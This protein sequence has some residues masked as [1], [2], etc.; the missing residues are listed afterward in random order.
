M[1]EV[2]SLE[3]IPPECAEYTGGRIRFSANGL[4]L[5][6]PNALEDKTIRWC[7]EDRGLS[8]RDSY[9]YANALSIYPDTALVPCITEVFKTKWFDP[10]TGQWKRTGGQITC[11]GFQ[12]CFVEYLTAGREYPGGRRME[13][14][15]GIF[16]PSPKEE[17]C[18]KQDYYRNKDIR[19]AYIRC[20]AG[21]II[22]G[23]S[24]AL[25]FISNALDTKPMGSL[26]E[27][28]KTS[29]RLATLYPTTPAVS[30]P[31][32]PPPTP[33]PEKETG[34]WVWIGLGVLGLL[35]LSEGEGKKKAS[36][37]Q[38]GQL[39]PVQKELFKVPRGR[40]VLK[41]QDISTSEDP[42]M[43][44]LER[45]GWKVKRVQEV[46]EDIAAKKTPD[47]FTG[48]TEPLTGGEKML[49]E[50]IDRCLERMKA[51]R[52][53]RG[54]QPLSGNIMTCESWYEDPYTGWHCFIYAPSCRGQKAC[55]TTGDTRDLKTCV[56]TKLVEP[57]SD[58]YKVKWITRCARYAPACST[59]QCLEKAAPMLR[60]AEPPEKEIKSIAR[61]LAAEATRVQK[62]A[63]PALAREI[64]SRGGIRPY[65]ELK[66]YHLP[67]RRYLMEEYMQIPLFM[68][69]K[70][71]LPLDEMADEM[72]LDEKELLRRISQEYG[73]G[74]VKRR[75]SWKDFYQEAKDIL[76]REYRTT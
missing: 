6:A 14:A 32:S 49:Q 62:E 70:K 54:G 23:W 71:G 68:R 35:M 41:R 30:P 25:A 38:L 10:L 9:A 4:R 67:G 64:L 56:E 18:I 22:P 48:K 57:K 5:T 27:I 12:K 24:G 17:F 19:A 53:R 15:P 52:S 51:S 63:G 44:C 50:A 26:Y 3:T 13:I 37:G 73:R 8:L 40:L 36:L 72:G 61:G 66:Q 59:I 47:I 31:V 76:L 55:K 28:I 75:F 34:V 74:K 39:E 1:I 58:R 45:Q 42:V 11:I 2:K 43:Q 20:V 46:Q 69:R 65:R 16:A 7:M 29:Y 21:D 60:P 33:K